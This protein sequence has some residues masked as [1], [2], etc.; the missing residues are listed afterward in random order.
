M[1][2]RSWSGVA[3][4]GAELRGVMDVR[5][6]LILA[7][8]GH[9]GRPPPHCRLVV[10]GFHF[11]Q[12]AKCP[13]GFEGVR[14]RVKWPSTIPRGA[15]NDAFDRA[16]LTRIKAWAGTSWFIRNGRGYGSGI[17]SY[18]VTF[19]KHVL[20]SDGHRFKA[21]QAT[22]CVRAENVKEAERQAQNDFACLRGIPHWNLHADLVEVITCGSTSAG[23]SS[24]G[25]AT[26]VA[27]RRS[28]KAHS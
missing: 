20:S 18:E 21:P 5:A 8:R 4:Q 10:D 17:T 27:V 16:G 9:C 14:W 23:P 11:S 12:A 1:L 15:F 6:P 26:G 24:G 13:S 2:T 7:G 25:D 19:F 28:R 3:A 22:I